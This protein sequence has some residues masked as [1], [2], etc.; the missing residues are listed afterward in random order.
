MENLYQ[1]IYLS[2]KLLNAIWLRKPVIIC[3]K[4][5]EKIN[6][7]IDTVL[8]FIPD[9]RQWIV[10]GSV[11]KRFIYQKSNIK[12]LEL[13]DNQLIAQSLLSSFEEEGI[14]TAP[15]QL[16]SFET[17][18]EL[19]GQVLN[20]LDHGWIA[21]TSLDTDKII[22][23]FPSKISLSHHQDFV[24]IFFLNNLSENDVIDQQLIKTT[25]TRPE[26]VARLLLQKKMSEIWYIGQA[27]IKEIEQGKTISQTEIEELYHI[28]T[29]SFHKSIEVL[30]SETRL[31]ISKYITFTPKV[32][33]SILTS[34]NKLNGVFTSMGLS[35]NRLIGIKK[36]E[37]FPVNESQFFLPF[38]VLLSKLETDYQFG[39]NINLSFEFTT[40]KQLLFLKTDRVADFDDMVFAFIVESG[41]NIPLLLYEVENILK[42]I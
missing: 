38:Y 5:G 20:Q 39:K 16:I 13:R 12:I 23:L 30:E 7:Y 25:S 32:I 10:F 3:T 1:N 33:S 34:I 42:E 6:N 14:S 36:K 41:I 31:A 21:L 28:D 35:Q 26:S 19:F 17:D 9:Y 24:K 40:N 15:I 37:P 18:E 2:S 27:L 29:H 4:D 22:N 11:P 8:S